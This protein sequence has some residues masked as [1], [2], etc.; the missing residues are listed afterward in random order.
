MS[1]P[2][3]ISGFKA[4]LSGAVVITKREL[5][6]YFAT[7]LAYVFLVIFLMMT[8]IFTFYVGQFFDRGIAGLESFSFITP[9]CTCFLSRPFPC[10]C[11]RRS[12]NPARLSCC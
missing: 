8:G 11:G 3:Q 6:S 10:A 7:P 1:N 5:A 4:A 9:G 2:E 12:V